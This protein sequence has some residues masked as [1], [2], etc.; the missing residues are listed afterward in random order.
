MFQFF[1]F[2]ICIKHFL[3]ENFSYGVLKFINHKIILFNIDFFG[4]YHFN[5]K[6]WIIWNVVCIKNESPYL[7]TT[8]RLKWQLFKLANLFTIILGQLCIIKSFFI[9]PKILKT[10][11]PCY[12]KFKK[13]K[14]YEFGIE[15]WSSTYNHINCEYI[16]HNDNN[17]TLNLS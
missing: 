9:L 16:T 1:S 6:I 15:P 8:L 13:K 11:L 10:L 2:N 3:V 14:L 4:F 12:S 7:A 5:V 17:R